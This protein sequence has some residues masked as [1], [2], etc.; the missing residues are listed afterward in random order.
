MVLNGY[1]RPCEMIALGESF[2]KAAISLCRAQIGSHQSG[3]R[4]F[5]SLGTLQKGSRAAQDA[6]HGFV[7]PSRGT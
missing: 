7:K 2:K 6:F 3:L 4:P 1:E 5:H